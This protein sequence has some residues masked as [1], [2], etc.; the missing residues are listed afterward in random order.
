MGFHG[1]SE[2]HGFY[3]FLCKRKNPNL[4]SFWKRILK[5][6]LIAF[7][8]LYRP[9]SGE[10]KGMVIWVFFIFLKKH[11]WKFVYP[12]FLLFGNLRFMVL[13]REVAPLNPCT[14]ENDNKENEESLKVKDMN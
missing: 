1:F 6:A 9:I 8:S 7:Y 10:K 12:N 5:M 11:F 4:T 13:A 3:S 14:R 2:N